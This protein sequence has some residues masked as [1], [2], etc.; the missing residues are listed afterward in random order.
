MIWDPEAETMPREQRRRLQLERFQRTLAHVAASVPFYRERF[1]A[2]GLR[3]AAVRDRSDLARLPCT[4]KTDLREHYPFGL[5]AVPREQVVRV[6]A[7]S[8]PRGKPTVVGYT[9]HDLALW[10]AVMARCLARAGVRPGMAVQVAY[11]YGLFTGG[12]GFHSGAELMGCTVIPASS[13]NT[14][15][16]LQLL[17]RGVNLY[18]LEVERVLLT[19][20]ELAPHDRLVVT[21]PSALDELEV[22]AE[23]VEEFAAAAETWSQEPAGEPEPLA[24]LRQRIERRLRDETTLS[25]RVRLHPPKA[26]PRSEGKAVRVIDRRGER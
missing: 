17:Q 11:G 16:Q 18:P 23:L 21:R 15:R 3:P 26:L 9:R 5:L 25:I 14:A 24:A 13:G 7:S 12:L 19:F 8:G 22:Q 6:Q 20:P 1:A 10:S 4:R 2:A